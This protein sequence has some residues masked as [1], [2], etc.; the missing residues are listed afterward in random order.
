LKTEIRSLPGEIPCGC[1][2]R[3]PLHRRDALEFLE[4]ILNDDEFVHGGAR[5]GLLAFLHRQEPLVIEDKGIGVVGGIR[6][7]TRLWSAL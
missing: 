7:F 6:E 1:N 5:P 3:G 4:A 2:A